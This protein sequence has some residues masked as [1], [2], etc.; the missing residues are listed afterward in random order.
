MA[1]LWI[2]EKRHADGSLDLSEPQPTHYFG[3][4]SITGMTDDVM[5]K[6]VYRHNADVLLDGRYIPDWPRVLHSSF[7][8]RVK[9]W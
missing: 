6:V 8:A 3:L 4:K 1:K 2:V 9:T 7:V 5:A